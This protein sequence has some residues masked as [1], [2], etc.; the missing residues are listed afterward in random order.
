MPQIEF[1][2]NAPERLHYVCRFLRKANAHDWRVGVLGSEAVLRQLDAAL[3]SF[4]EHDFLPHCTANDSP[5]MQQAS[6]ILLSPD[7]GRLAGW[8][9][10]VNLGDD[11][12]EGFEQFQRVIEIVPS[13][14]HGKMTARQ[15]WR[16]YAAQGFEL[17]QHD[18]SK[19]ATA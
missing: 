15:R 5:H 8:P 3:W 13:D 16:H 10:L 7:V 1:H 18:L 19:V 4:S 11:V 9:M 14:D 12:P 6:A 17:T 2:F